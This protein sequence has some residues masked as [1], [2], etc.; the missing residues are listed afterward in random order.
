[1]TV[2]FG[3]A[4]ADSMIPG[5]ALLRK[6]V[7]TQEQAVEL[8]NRGVV[9]C[10]NPSHKATIDAMA[11]RCGIVV[12]IPSTAPKI[13]LEVGDSVIVLG[14]RGLPRLDATRH[15]YTAE[16][17]AKATFSFSLWTRLE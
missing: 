6:Q 7:L 4:F 17:I 16:E 13:E 1:M 3:F 8:I 12:P 9:P 10:L 5:N 14:V 15:E 11:V 2:Y